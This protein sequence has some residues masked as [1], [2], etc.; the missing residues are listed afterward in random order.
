[1]PSRILLNN[2]KRLKTVKNQ[3]PAAV[4][5][6]LSPARIFA[7][8]TADNLWLGPTQESALSQ[9]VLNTPLKALLGPP[10]SGRSTLLRQLAKPT[11]SW[12][13]LAVPGPQRFK[14]AV[15]KG[16]LRSAGLAVDGL[17]S[18]EMRRM[19]DV[20]L[21]ERLAH[22][23]RVLVVI[24]DAD[25]FGPA[26][27]AEVQRITARNGAVGP[28]PELVLA[29]VHLDERS[30]PAADHLRAHVS[31][32]LSVL[33]W[34]SDREVGW[35]L[36]WRLGRFGLDGLF[37]PPAVR[38]IARCTRG[39]FTAVDHLC[40]IALLLLR[41]NNEDHVDVTLV[42]EAL[43][44]L[45][46]RRGALDV[47]PSRAPQGQLLI[48]RDGD[49]VTRVALRDRLLIGRS[50][51]NDLCLDSDYLSRHHALILRS[52]TGFSV[53]DLNSA[54]GVL[55]NGEAASVAPINDGDVIRIGPYRIKVEL[56]DRLSRAGAEVVD[57][58]L[59]DTAV[60]PGVDGGR[61]AGLRVVR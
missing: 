25:T 49:V 35:Y 33:S 40:Q 34:L 23:Q 39:S 27:F 6:E 22:G 37:T 51:M 7:R 14:N 32:A 59:A 28:A 53:T 3:Q 60:M 15:L 9:L 26:A 54:N 20:F 48:S 5:R 16:L 38:L 21:R 56:A 58:L 45:Q 4:L 11:D 47:R 30:S 57:Q 55:L 12:I 46:R 2:N 41:K 50:D 29:L 42:R 1:M 10:S 24:D 61:E 13:V 52:G 18:R 43:D 44:A 19:L 17:D 8:P 36:N 31:P